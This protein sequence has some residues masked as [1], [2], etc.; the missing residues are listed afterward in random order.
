MIIRENETIFDVIKG[1]NYV[2]LDTETTGLDRGEIVSIAV[3]DSSGETMIDRL[4]KPVGKIPQSAINIHGIT[5]DMVKDAQPF[6]DVLTYLKPL[7]TD[8]NVIVYNAVYDRKMLHQSAEELGI[9]R[10]DWKTLSTWWCAME[11]FAE[12]YG[13]WNE[14]R[15]NYKWQKLTTACHYYNIPVVNAHGALGDCL[16]TL[17]VCKKMVGL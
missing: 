9:E 1:E 12:I 8:T 15:G 10:I 14:Y 17:E 11:A 3:I 16:M 2:I 5:D 13:E 4:V 7:L 6:S